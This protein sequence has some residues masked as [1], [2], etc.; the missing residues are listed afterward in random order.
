MNPRPFHGS[1]GKI[2]GRL[3][4]TREALGLTQAQAARQLGVTREAVGRWETGHEPGAL[5]R[6]VI[7]A[8]IKGSTARKGGPD[9]S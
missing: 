7:E 5:A 9:A 4:R 2:G 3:L 8:W 6:R 1:R